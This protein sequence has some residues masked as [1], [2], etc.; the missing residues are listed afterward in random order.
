MDRPYSK[1]TVRVGR[2]E[3]KD[4][5]FFV[6]DEE[7][8][9]YRKL[10][11]FEEIYYG[12]T[13]LIRRAKHICWEIQYGF[14]R[15]FKGY[16]SVDAFDTG[17]KFVKRYTKILTQYKNTHYG[18]PS[19]M[20]EEEWDN[21]IDEMLYHLRYMDEEIVDKELTK[22]VPDGWIPTVITTGRIMEKHKD[23]F[24]ALFSKYFYQL[25]D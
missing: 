15:M 18:Y 25:W 1:A 4:A 22:D 9:Q 2:D 16:D 10:N 11:I 8:L 19:Y 6:F 14:Q 3:I 5:E 20:T 12:I 21:I 7:S 23:E 24:F 13:R 17:N